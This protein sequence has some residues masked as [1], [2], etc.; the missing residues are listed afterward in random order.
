MAGLFEGA[1]VL[2]TG[3]SGGFGSGAAR[4]Y[5]SEG[6]RLVLSDYD[7]GRLEAIAGEVSDACG[8][9]VAMLAGDV[10]EESL[11][12][13]LVALAV[14][15]FGRLDVAVNNAGIAQDAFEK[16]PKTS[17]RE[18]RRILDVDLLGMF[19][20]LKH[21]LPVMERQF[22][23]GGK[24]GSIVN[25]ASVAGVTGASGLAVYAAAK[26]GV[27]GLTRSTAQEYARLGIRINAVCPSFAR[28]PMA[29]DM[30]NVEVRGRVVTEEQLVRGIP[31]G[32][33]A[34]VEEVVEAFVFASS[35]KNSFMTG[36]TIH[37][38][39]GLTGY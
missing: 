31:M 1:T 33:L 16:L 27:V 9:E 32:R 26:H 14:E 12:E 18:A 39:G 30:L 17:S 24:G 15:R 34:E 38:D 11:S 35:P 3:A 19:F 5:A 23:S 22:R 29:T 6:A 4:R 20:A 21:Q 37:V 25:V 10:A 13:K 7:E 36:Q 8:C 28:T 2:I